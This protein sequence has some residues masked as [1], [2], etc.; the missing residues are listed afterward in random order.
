MWIDVHAHLEALTGRDLAAT[1]AEAAEAG[2][3]AILSTATDLAGAA[4][5]ADQCRT[6]PGIFGAVG[7]SPFDSPS[8]P[9]GWERTLLSFLAQER[10]IALGEIGLDASNPKYPAPDVQ[11]PVFEKQLSIAAETGKPV[12]VHSRGAGKQVAEICR[13]F[14][15][16]KVLFHC[17]TGSTSSLEYILACGYSI[18]FSGIVTFNETV[19]NLVNLVPP[20]RLFIE[21]DTPY[22]APVPHRGK[23]NR[24]A[25]VTLVGETVAQC[26]DVSPERMQ[27]IV[28]QNF[29][30]FFRT[31]PFP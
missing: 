6:C 7:I 20:D 2:V 25:W 8:L 5:V 26:K 11:R 16:E 21:T 3:A 13:S 12:V 15:L 10:I 28:S 29:S 19:R 18:S 30:M 17:F 9:A 1:V 4:A 22:L 31:A 27:E 24:P 14:G 23:T